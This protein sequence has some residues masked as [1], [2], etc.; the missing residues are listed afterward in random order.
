M[1]AILVVTRGKQKSERFPLDPTKQN[2]LGRGTDCEVQI[3]DP[4]WSR[5]HAVV[6]F[7][8]GQW[9]LTLQPDRTLTIT[10]PDRT[11]HTTGPLTRHQ[12]A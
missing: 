12:A 7:H 2:K 4:L 1:P 9:Q 11:T 10:H 5:V 6:S 3:N 8:E